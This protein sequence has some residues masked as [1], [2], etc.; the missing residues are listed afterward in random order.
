MNPSFIFNVF[1]RREQNPA[2]NPIYIILL[3]DHNIKIKDE[4]NDEY[5]NKLQAYHE[6]HTHYQ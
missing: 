3:L 4:D 2:N 6:N 1:L 5:N